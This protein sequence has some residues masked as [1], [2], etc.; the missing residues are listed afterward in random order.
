MTPV[1][2]SIVAVLVVGAMLAS[3]GTVAEPPKLRHASPTELG[4]SGELPAKVEAAVTAA[5][6]EGKLPGCVVVIG[7]R[8]RI[9]HAKL[10]GNRRIEPVHEAMTLDTV[11]DVAS[12]TKPIATATSAM[13]LIERGKLRLDDPVAKHLPEFA[14]EG[15]GNI[16]VEH[17]LLHTGGL[18]ADNPL[19][20]YA[21]GRE[22]AIERIC[23]LKPVAA[24]G[25]RFIYSD[26]SF[27]VL[28]LMVEKVSGQTLDEFA[29]DNIFRPLRMSETMFRPGEAFRARAA[30]TEKRNGE[31]L[32][33]EV[34]DPRAAKLGGVA[35]HAGLFSTA[36][37]L[38]VY[39]EMML[40]GGKY[41]GIQ[42][43]K[44]ETWEM[45][46]RPREVPRRMPTASNSPQGQD[47]RGTLWVRGLGWDIR[48]GYSTNRGKKLSDSAFGHGGFTGTSLWIDPENE[49]F[50]IF[51]S[52]RLHPDGKGSVNPLAGRIAEL[53]VE[54]VGK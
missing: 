13:I 19:S 22:R 48:T 25:E 30:P 24:P 51:L 6:A 11:F 7:Y 9:A 53:A 20:D 47:A 46:T 43:L 14:A 44:R 34:H 26:V 16:T 40:R 33:G 42:V 5:I 52:S 35:G 29:R 10:Y 45:M 21:D 2:R 50:V 54:A 18:I 3:R 32:V 12:L 39:A 28:G 8:G 41:G 37:D 17:L 36:E 38:A 4:M 15:K 23:A 1:R 49:L 27:V 31:W